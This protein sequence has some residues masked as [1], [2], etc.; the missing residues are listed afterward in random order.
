MN[1]LINNI[2]FH[3]RQTLNS[4]SFT[5]GFLL[6]MG[7]KGRNTIICCVSCGDGMGEKGK[8]QFIKPGGGVLHC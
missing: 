7:K 2:T 5:E 8:T 3:Y 4:S 6:T 1:R